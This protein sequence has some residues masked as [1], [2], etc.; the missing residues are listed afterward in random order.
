MDGEQSVENLY[1]LDFHKCHTNGNIEL[2]RF[3][4][5]LKSIFPEVNICIFFP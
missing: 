2:K 5:P 1:H 3:R 4:Q